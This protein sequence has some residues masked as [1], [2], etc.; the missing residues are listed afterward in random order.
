MPKATST[1][2]SVKPLLCFGFWRTGLDL[3]FTAR[4][5]WLQMV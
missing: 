3:T 5:A 1:S 4:L 2:M